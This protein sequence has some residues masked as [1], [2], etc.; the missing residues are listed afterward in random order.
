MQNYE[1]IYEGI[2][3]TRIRTVTKNANPQPTAKNRKT[4]LSRTS[5]EENEGD[6]YSN[7]EVISSIMAT[8]ASHK[9]KSEMERG[10]YIMFTYTKP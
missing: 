3:A 5:R 2:P 10:K 6:A 8:T 1:R 9:L 7:S 4:C